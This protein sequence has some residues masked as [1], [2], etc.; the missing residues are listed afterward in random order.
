[1]KCITSLSSSFFNFLIKLSNQL[2]KTS[3][4]LMAGN[5][6]MVIKTKKEQF[7]THDL[8]FKIKSHQYKYKKV[9]KHT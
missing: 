6:L 8:T 3:G 5:D 1:M 2:N 7:A 9:T 4:T